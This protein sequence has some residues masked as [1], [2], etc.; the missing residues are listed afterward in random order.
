MILK[1]K[2]SQDLK[3]AMKSGDK[4]RLQTIRSIRASILEFEKSGSGKEMNSEEEIRLLST[5]AKK[6][7]ESIEQFSN[8]GREDLAK[9]EESEL[10]IIMSYLPEQ[11]SA[12]DIE[13]EVIQISEKVGAVSKADFGKLMG[14]AVKEMKGKADGRIIKEIVEKVLGKN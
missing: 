9:A 4:V 14:A 6:R 11:L 10:Q 12:E 7:K 1:D 2:I 3:D 5:A 13:K 8:G